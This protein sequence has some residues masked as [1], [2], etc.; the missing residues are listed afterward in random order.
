VADKKAVSVTRDLKKAR[1]RI[2]ELR[3][4]IN[5]HNYLYYVLDSPEISDAEFDVLIRELEKLEEQYPQFITPD[6][7]TQRIGVPPAEGFPPFRHRARMFS[8]SDAFDYDELSAFFS[9]LR[10]AL[11][12]GAFEYVC[13][14]KIDG[15][16]VSLTYEKGLYVR[17]ATRGDGEAGEDVTPNLKTLRSVPLRIRI[18]S[19]PEVFEVKGEVY[20]SADKF[21]ELNREREERGLTLFANPRNAAAGSLRQLDP[22]VTASRALD[23]FAYAVGYISGREFNAQYEALQF[24]KEAGFKVNPH[25]K[26]AKSEEEVFAYCREWEEKRD[27]LPYEIDGVVVKVNSLVQQERL[28]VTAKSPRWAIA[29]K[30]APKQATTQ[31]EDIVVQVGRTGALTPVAHLRPV[32]V[33][34]TTVSRATLHNEDEIRRKDVRIGD[35]VLIQ[36]AGDVI[37][38]VVSVVKAK[39][40][41]KEKVFRMPKKCPVC[42]SDVF[43][44]GGEAVTRCTGIAC[45]AQ[46][47]EHLL[48]YAGRGAMDIDGL[49]P[50]VVEELMK[51]KWVTDVADLYSLTKERLLGIPHYADKAAENLLGAIDASRE[52]PLSRLLFALGIRHVGSHVATMLAR[53]FPSIEEL[54]RASYEDLVEIPEIGPRIA[55]SVVLF[56]KQDRN[57]KV[58]EKLKKAKIRMEEAPRRAEA[59]RK[60]EGKTFVLT[61]T[62][63]YFSREEATERI[64]ALGGR[65]SSS[66]S[67]K[68][69]YVVAGAEPGNKYDKAKS[70]GVNIIDEEEFKK[71]I[72]K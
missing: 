7:P 55:E 15:S 54:K 67:K 1:K 16:A 5:H 56:F 35:T 30:F 57:L 2:E 63:E 64:E 70:L 9:R 71:L 65:V 29:F 53:H 44:P 38:E 42:G 27:A 6:S 62:L 41:G 33:G 52:R 8:L 36:R 25:I 17:G 51:R 59:A 13:E 20:L 19:P 22:K 12:D 46:L 23:I 14:L 50:A 24:L 39:R 45:P 49:G 37:P 32:Q 18:P 69:D 72:G 68:T 60:F 34:G 66:V 28:G 48:H 43:R 58:L 3:E 26:L 10:K 21:R 40:T 4:Q 61:G 11:P 47:R 31:I